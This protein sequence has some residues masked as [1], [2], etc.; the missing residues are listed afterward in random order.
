MK[1][2]F[3]FLVAL[4]FSNLA[5][6]D[7]Y[8]C[9][10]MIYK[11]GW[12]VKYEHLGNTWGANTKKHGAVSSSVGSS[13]EKTTSSVDPGVSTGNIMSS[14]QYF[15]SWGECS[16]LEYHITKQLREQYIEQN[17]GE[18]KRQVAMGQ[19]YHVDAL[20]MISGC[21]NLGANEWARALQS[22][23][24]ELYDLNSGVAFADHLNTIVMS[25]NSLRG[26][27]AIL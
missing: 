13:V 20:A 6:A 5:Y 16:M 1:V 27:C 2:L 7:A 10:K 8:S 11:D 17:L 4:G 14:V 22:N 21:Q 3:G 26:N 18:I 9:A 24:E 15:S 25:Q 23:T 19:G 12:L